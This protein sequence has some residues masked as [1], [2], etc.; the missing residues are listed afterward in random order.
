MAMFIELD[1]NPNRY[2]TIHNGERIQPNLWRRT[3]AIQADCDELNFIKTK[4][5]NIRCLFNSKVVIFVGE[6]AKLIAA[7]WNN[8]Q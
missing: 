1:N 8:I 2:I 3:T 5:S 4:F 6:D 7:N